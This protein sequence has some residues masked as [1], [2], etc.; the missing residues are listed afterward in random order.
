MNTP[1]PLKWPNG[2][3][4]TEAR[5]RETAKFKQTLET[6]MRALNKEVNLLPGKNLVLSS[7]CALGMVRSGDPGGGGIFQLQRPSRGDSLRQVA[8]CR[9]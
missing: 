4:R 3:P 9:A 6:A 7:N 8:A 2:W 5:L 1:Y